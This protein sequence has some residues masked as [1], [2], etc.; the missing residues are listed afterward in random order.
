M[1]LASEI[2]HQATRFLDDEIA[3]AALWSWLEQHMWDIDNRDPKTAPLAHEVELLLTETAHGDWTED[4][5]RD[6]LREILFAD[7][8]DAARSVTR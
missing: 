3:V 8:H 7:T 2:R 6:K 5:L 1:D 4:E